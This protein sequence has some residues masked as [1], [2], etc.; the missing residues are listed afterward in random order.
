MLATSGANDGLWDWDLKLNQIYLSTRW[1]SMLG[2]TEEEI[3]T[4]INQ[5]FDRVHEDDLETVKANLSRHLHGLTPHFESEY[6]MLHKDGSYRWIQT[7]GL[8]VRDSGLHSPYRMA[9]SQ[10]DITARKKAE[11]QLLHD[12][13][14]DRSPACQ[15]ALC[16]LTAWGMPLNEAIAISRTRL[17]CYSW[18]WTVKILNDSLGHFFGD[19]MLIAFAQRLNACLRSSD[20]AARLGGDEFV[21]LLE[22]IQEINDATKTTERIIQS[23]KSPFLL[24]NQEVVVTASIGIVM[25][26]TASGLISYQ[27]PEDVLRDADIAMYRAK[28]Q[29][30]NCF[31]I[32]DAS[33]RTRAITRLEMENE[34]RA[35]LER[36]EF[37]LNYQPICSLAND[38]ITG[39][40]ALLRWNSPSRG[41]VSP[42]EFIPVAE[43]IGLIVP[44]GEWVLREACQQICKWQQLFPQDPPLTINVNISGVQFAHPSLLDQVRT[45]LEETGLDPECLKFELTESVF[46]ENAEH[47]NSILLKLRKMGVNLQIDDFGTG[48]SSLAYLQHFPIDAIKIDQSFIR[49]ID[50]NKGDTS[51]GIE[52]IRTIVA[53]ARDLG[54]ESVAEGVETLDQLTQLK[55]LNCQ[56]GQGFFL[57][58]TLS[59]ESVEVKMAEHFGL[60]EP[61]VHSSD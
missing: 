40:E 49:H 21:V 59:A 41:L 31:V 9:G 20:T 18:T 39:F 25:G 22:D 38:H 8:T 10:S 45:I 60:L 3:G 12:A 30:K 43:E 56:Y 36:G 32:F 58:G 51:G 4:G 48:Y 16:F 17:L 35:G 19:Q 14:H 26:L 50:S 61:P 34:L 37:R 44:I 53:L 5:W 33:Q 46:M 47:A 1:K 11:E 24:D 23:L 6:R 54:M 55:E 13:F 57:G 15:T 7:R 29:G 27:N 2:Y 28:S 52:I 42:S